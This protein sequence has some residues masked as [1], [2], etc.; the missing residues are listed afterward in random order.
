MCNVQNARARLGL[1]NQLSS[2]GANVLL[3]MHHNFHVICF[4]DVREGGRGNL[5]SGP[6]Q[7]MCR[8]LSYNVYQDFFKVGSR[9]V[10]TPLPRCFAKQV[11]NVVAFD[12]GA[13]DQPK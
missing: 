6:Q 11:A 3:Q 1:S 5:G 12:G 4:R 13:I 7:C 2:L 10:S 8:L 9:A